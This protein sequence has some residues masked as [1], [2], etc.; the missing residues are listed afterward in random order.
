MKNKLLV[1][2]LTLSRFILSLVYIDCIIILPDKIP[3]L[4][5]LF[6][7]ICMTDFLDGWLARKLGAVS[8][9]G[10][11]L[12]AFADL[13]F[14]AGSCAAL[15]FRGIFPAWMLAVI[16]LKFAEFWFTSSYARKAGFP[17]ERVFLFDL[18][19]KST[20]LILFAIPYAL[21]VLNAFCSDQLTLIAANSI[22]IPVAAAAAVSS[23]HRIRSIRNGRRLPGMN[24]A[25]KATSNI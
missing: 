11:V 14:V 22:C 9:A 1:N 21:L 6:A 12:D 5:I 16:L 17:I 20:A 10:A 25:E 4:S 15:V 23:I 24:T 18:L 8:N 7:V 2:S 19:G 13:F 3:L